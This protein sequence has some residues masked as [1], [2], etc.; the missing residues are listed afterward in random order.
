MTRSTNPVSDFNVEIIGE[1][2][3]E[4]PYAETLQVFT[5]KVSNLLPKEREIEF[6]PCIY[7]TSKQ[8]QL[9]TRDLI[10]TSSLWSDSLK[11][12]VYK[13]YDFLFK[14]EQLSKIV[15][16]DQIFIALMLESKS[17]QLKYEFIREKGSWVLSNFTKIDFILTKKLIQNSLTKK[18][19]RLE[20]F[21]EKYKVTFE[22]L[23]IEVKS[24]DLITVVGELHSSEGMYL[25][26]TS[27]FVYAIAYDEEG[28]II[29]QNRDRI[30][31]ERF[32][33]FEI[34]D[35]NLAGHDI[36]NRVRKIRVYPT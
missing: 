31:K 34:I 26:N 5:F 19:E 1:K 9:E 24:N 14:E 25:K 17:V 32:Y 18:L 3:V 20:V 7:I 28:I 21:E 15:N 8:E 29:A 23:T 11:P 30:H 22:S 13:I 4:K 35:F 33:G 16:G 10:N 12:N 2:K 36:V 6:M 27:F